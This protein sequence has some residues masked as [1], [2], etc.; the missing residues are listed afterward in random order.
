MVLM[1]QKPILGRKKISSKTYFWD[2]KKPLIATNP[3]TYQNQSKYLGLHLSQL[4]KN[5]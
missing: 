3:F 5:M 1:T 4:F 2:K